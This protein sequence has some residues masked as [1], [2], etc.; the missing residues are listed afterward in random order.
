[1]RYSWNEEPQHGPQTVYSARGRAVEVRATDNRHAFQRGKCGVSYARRRRPF[2][3]TFRVA[4]SQP[5][6]ASTSRSWA[7]QAIDEHLDSPIGRLW[8]VFRQLTRVCQYPA[9]LGG[10]P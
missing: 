4:S 8:V 6:G 3:S 9:V 7:P 1:M 2:R 10:L 5:S